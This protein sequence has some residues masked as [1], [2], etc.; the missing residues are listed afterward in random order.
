MRTGDED[1]VDAVLLTAVVGWFQTYEVPFDVQTA[2]VLCRAALSFYN[3]GLGD[4][5]IARRL[6]ETFLGPL[7]TKTNA[8]TSMAVH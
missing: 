7:S 3:E 4:Q 2:E 5:D 1:S 6:V 8:P